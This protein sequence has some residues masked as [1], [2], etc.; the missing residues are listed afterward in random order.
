M[1][2]LSVTLL[3]AVVPPNAPSTMSPPPAVIASACAPLTVPSVTSLAALLPVSAIVPPPA[4]S[5]VA[6]ATETPKPAEVTL[7]GPFNVTVVP[8]RVTP[9]FAINLPTEMGPD[10]VADGSE[11]SIVREPPVTNIVLVASMLNPPAPVRNFT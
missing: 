11:A 3:S 1:L 4:A 5:T 6:P 10:P 8:F 9:S 2:P 7:I